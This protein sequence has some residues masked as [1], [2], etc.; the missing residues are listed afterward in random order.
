MKCFL[1][2]SSKDKGSY[3]SIVAKKLSPNIEY[4]ELTFEEGMGNLEEILA[5]LDRSDI[6]VLFLSESAL[7]SE[8]VQKEI[9][10][11]KRQLENGE[12]TR[13]FP[14]IIEKEV[15]FRDERIPEWISDNYNLRP[16]LKPTIAA[17][18][19]RERMVE[20]S[21]KSHPMLK[22]RDQ[23]FVG[24]NE[25]IA[26]FERRM[27]DLSKD[28][29]IVIFSSGL[30]DIGRKSMMRNA[31]RKSNVIR[32]TYEPIRIDLTKEDSIEGLILK[33]A[34]FGLSDNTDISD[35]LNR[36]LDDKQELCAQLMQDVFA[37][38]ELILI[39]DRYCI[40]RYDRDIAPWFLGVVEKLEVSSL[41]ICVATSAKAAKYKYIRDNRFYFIELPELQK[42]EREGLFKRYCEFL[43]LSLSREEYSNFTPLLKGFPEQVTYAATLI[44]EMGVNEAFSKA[45]EIVSF[46]S[47]KA[48]ISLKRYDDDD[49][50]LSFLRF[51]SS[52]EFVSLDFVIGVSETINEP[53]AEFMNK[54]VADSVCESIGN[55]GQ[56]FRINEVIRDAILRDRVQLE[57]CYRQALE[58][59]VANFTENYSSEGFDVSEYHIAVKQAL[60]NG[61]ELPESMMIPAHFIQTMKD[62]YNKRSYN[63]VVSLADRVLENSDF[64]DEHTRQDIL[65]Y[66]CQSL[67]RLKDPRFTSEVQKISGPEH[68]FL[69]GFYYRQRRRF[70]DAIKR[71]KSAMNE[72][73]TEQRARREIV[74]VLTAIEEYEEALSLAKENYERYRS[75]PYL[76]Q[77]YFLCLLHGP[78]EPGVSDQLLEVLNSLD[79]IGGDRAE[80]MHASLFA[81]YEYQFGDK[82]KAFRLIE[83]AIQ[84]YSGIVYPILT[85]LDMAL[86]DMN[87]EVISVCIRKIQNEGL[88]GGHH[89]PITKAKAVLAALQG[90]KEKAMRIVDRDLASFSD[91]ARQKL[92]ARIKSV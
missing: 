58:K 80:E 18:R 59:F 6:F 40:V 34:D 49:K 21:W 85:K 41:K 76:A 52:F 23:I 7:E 88:S 5:A 65:Y 32:E 81:R 78:D 63:D 24:R 9:T 26:D 87:A 79:Q 54:F 1:S 19:I 17:K 60:T 39:E 20:A 73:R 38:N 89:T 13:F 31:L 43:E 12:L 82:E 10:E 28:Q 35:L 75:N 46:S 55:T 51:L 44:N 36:T 22:N 47:Y 84:N 50:L 69:F 74:F 4:D 42:V 57:D 56:Y 27:D 29:P 64:Y 25:H 90:D 2:H 16:I 71:Y 77:A 92:I 37:F 45:D 33:L 14:I 15:T 66:L 86:H 48:S 91:T 68:D 62:L 53:L 3:V 83:E 30:Q 8:W 11:A 70:D 61:I 67:A 72:R